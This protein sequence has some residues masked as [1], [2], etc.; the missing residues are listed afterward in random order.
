MNWINDKQLKDLKKRCEKEDF[1][2]W[3]TSYDIFIRFNHIDGDIFMVVESSGN[4][5]MCPCNDDKEDRMVGFNIK[6]LKKLFVIL[7]ECGIKFEG[8]E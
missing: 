4:V 6:K 3:P 8:E 5:T 7:D 1:H 2:V